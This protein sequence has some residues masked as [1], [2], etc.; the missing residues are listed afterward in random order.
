M[1][2]LRSPTH[3]GRP[4]FDASYARIAE[5][6]PGEHVGVFLCGPRTLS[7]TLYRLARKHTAASTTT[8]HYH[9][10]NF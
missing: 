6:H 3:Y 10:E 9:K 2:G 5:R 7:K 4:D 1:T 8:F